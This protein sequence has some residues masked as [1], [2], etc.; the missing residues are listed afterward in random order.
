MVS[1]SDTLEYDSP[2]QNHVTGN[3]TRVFPDM[4]QILANNT[5][6]VSGACPTPGATP[7]VAQIDCFSEFLPTA[8]YVGF[9]ANAAPAA[10]N[11]KLTARDG[12]GGVNS[13]T[14]TLRKIGP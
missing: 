4:R 8:S 14:T 2:G 9:G 7:T 3:P 5:N 12:R 10:L 1:S 11:F 13:A 6:A